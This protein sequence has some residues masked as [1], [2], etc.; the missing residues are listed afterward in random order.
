[1]KSKSLVL[2]VAALAGFATLNAQDQSASASASPSASAG[3]EQH[4]KSGRHH[5]FGHLLK[6]LNL[7]DAQ[8][9]QVKQYF[10]DNKQTFRTDRVNL[11]KA[12]QAINSAIEKNPS[13]D[14]NIRS[15]SANV[16]SARIELAAQRAKFDGF[17]QSILTPEQKQTLATLQQKRDAKMQARINRLSQSAS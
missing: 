4:Q 13:D 1:M 7:T 8:K 9:Q 6:Q 10:S 12:K 15:L 2:C 3:T 5:E 16:A 17:L 14:A 11:L